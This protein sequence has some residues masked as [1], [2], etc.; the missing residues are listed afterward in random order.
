M[1][2]QL[3]G[4]L[5]PSTR[6]VILNDYPASL[7]VMMIL[8]VLGL[9]AA[10]LLSRRPFVMDPMGSDF[11][12]GLFLTT[13]AVSFAAVLI[14][15]LARVLR[16]FRSGRVTT[17]TIISVVVSLRGPVTF[18]F[19]FEDGGHHIRARMHVVG[20]KTVQSLKQGDPAEVLYDPARPRRA[21]IARFFQAY[22]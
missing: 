9:C 2:A 19:A 5:K 21:I 18:D 15:R 8:G 13:L 22:T 6:K 20:W 14:W 7:A 17:A 16:L 11:P 1:R 12:V 3:L 10:Q 4:D